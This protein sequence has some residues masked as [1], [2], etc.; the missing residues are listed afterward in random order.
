[1]R[2]DIVE[3]LTMGSN[4]EKIVK[5]KQ[6]VFAAFPVRYFHFLEY[7]HVKLERFFFFKTNWG[8]ETIQLN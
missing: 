7:F 4:Y 8:S 1:M 3:A 6:K 2:L 5:I